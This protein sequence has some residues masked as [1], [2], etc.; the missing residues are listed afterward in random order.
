MSKSMTQ[1][2]K[3]IYNQINQL[4]YSGLVNIIKNGIESTPLGL[5]EIDREGLFAKDDSH[6]LIVLDGIYVISNK[7][8]FY[9]LADFGIDEYEMGDL[10]KPYSKDSDSNSNS[11]DIVLEKDTKNDN[12][13]NIENDTSNK[14]YLGY[15]LLSVMMKFKK[16]I[17]TIL[18]NNPKSSSYVLDIIQIVAPAMAQEYSGVPLMIIVA[19]IIIICKN[20]IINFINN[21][22]TLTYG[23]Y[24][25]K[26]T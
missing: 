19:A 17:I 9:E 23:G 2:V 20:G 18:H 25:L 21:S 22:G 3:D 8:S 26:N 12:N 15:E 14:P 5:S 11:K 4:D 24:T 10:N 7:S 13:S 1:Q 16:E 6:V